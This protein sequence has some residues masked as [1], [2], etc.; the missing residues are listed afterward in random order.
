MLQ[1]WGTD[2]IRAFSPDFWVHRMEKELGDDAPLVVISDIRFQ[3]EADLVTRMGG[4]IIRIE[5][6][7][8]ATTAPDHASEANW[9][10]IPFDYVIRN[11]LDI[12]VY[13]ADD[14]FSFVERGP[15][16]ERD[17]LTLLSSSC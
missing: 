7:V 4:V 2:M 16:T 8:G 11:N 1:H 9:D 10:K 17:F 14:T 15:K 3:N 5:R 13:R 6:D 12:D